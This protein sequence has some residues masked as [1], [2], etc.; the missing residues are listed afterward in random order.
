MLYHFTDGKTEAGEGEMYAPSYT[1]N[2]SWSQDL[3]LHGPS[4]HAVPATLSRNSDP[5]KPSDG[6]SAARSGPDRG[7]R[8]VLRL[9]PQPQAGSPCS[10]GPPGGRVERS[11]LAVSSF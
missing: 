1:A 4:Q 6:Q 10:V 8:E 9:A 3:E 2:Q 11:S 5:E 7:E